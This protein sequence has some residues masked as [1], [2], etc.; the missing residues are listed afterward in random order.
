VIVTR[1]D[2]SNFDAIAQARLLLS[3]LSEAEFRELDR[4]LRSSKKAAKDFLAARGYNRRLV[5]YLKVVGG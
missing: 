4:L 3:R 5:N 2:S 1:Q